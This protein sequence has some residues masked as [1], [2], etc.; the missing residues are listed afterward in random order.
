MATTN[1][2]RH[3]SGARGGVRARV[4]AV[5]DPAQLS[6]LARV[7]HDLKLM[8]REGS[9]FDLMYERL[10]ASGRAAPTASEGVDSVHVVVPRR[11]L[12]PSVIRFIA[13][14]EQ[15]YQLAQRERIALGLL[16]QTE[17]LSAIELAARLELDGPAALRSWIARL[18]ELGLVERSG[19]TAATRYFVHPSLLRVAGLDRR[20]TLRRVQPHRLRALIVEDLERF[21]DSSISDIHRRVGPEVPGRTVKRALDRLIAEGRLEPKGAR[22]WRRYRVCPSI[23]LASERGR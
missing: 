8:E 15:K 18:L 14:A 19:R 3:A 10:L 17:G 1:V 12:Q 21:P 6:C 22:R 9:G 23:D 5:V 16:A 4:P 7:F 13:D 11:V 20:T 2:T